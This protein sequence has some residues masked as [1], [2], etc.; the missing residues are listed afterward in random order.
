METATPDPRSLSRLILDLC[1]VDSTTGLEAN[2]LPL[3]SERLEGLGARIRLQ[4]VEGGRSNLLALWSRPRVLFSTHLDTVPPYLPPRLENG[5]IRGRGACDAKGAMACMLEAIRT[6]LADGLRG[7][8]FLG[9]VGEETDSLGARRAL[10]L[11]PDLAGLEAVVNGEPTGNRL[12]T[13]QKGSLH[14]RLRCRGKAAHSGTPEAGVNAAFPML[15]WIA[16]LRR[17]PLAADP[18]LGP[19]LWNLGT[20]SAGRAINIVPDLAEADL[21]ARIVDGS[22]FVEDVQ[23]LRPDLGEVEVVFRRAAERFPAIDGF[24]FA[25]MPFASDAHLLR[26]LARD[27]FVVLTGPGSILVAHTDEEHLDLEEATAG[28]AQYAALG[29]LLL[30]RPR[31]DEYVI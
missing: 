13:G 28:A 2:L 25:P 19:E 8:A 14:L 6:L 7:I 30:A 24:S 29:R 9:V 11:G 26:N 23:R 18:L 17:L 3:L 5:R 21:F 20:L 15:D 1:R 31:G 22:T 10:E 16:A 27:R 4:P 12:A